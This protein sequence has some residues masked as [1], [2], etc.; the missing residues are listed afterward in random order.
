MARRPKKSSFG[1]NLFWALM[2]AL[3]IISFAVVFVL[4]CRPL[5]YLDIRLLKLDAAS[6]VPASAIRKDYDS[7]VHYLCFWNRKPLALGSFAMSEQ[8]R[9]HFA[10]CKRIFDAVQI[11][12]I[13]TGIFTVI[14]FV[15]HKHGGNARYL[16]LAGILT[17]AIPAV[18]GILAVW[19]W[20]LVFT[21]FHKLL[22]RNDYWLFDSA[23]DPI[24]LV[25]PDAFFFQ[26]AIVIFAIILL[27]GIICLS[28]AFRRKRRVAAWRAGMR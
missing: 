19:R 25:L 23:R 26:C 5:Y 7:I 10:D 9:I 13:V 28:R 6:G 24:I 2:I 1:S 12:C 4:Y 17:I 3:F 27:G 15:L 21:T 16:R 18:L 11:L 20:D 8:G 14:S 22:F